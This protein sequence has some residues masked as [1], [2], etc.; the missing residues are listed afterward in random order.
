M[1]KKRLQYV[2]GKDGLKARETIMHSLPPPRKPTMSAPSGIPPLRRGTEEKNDDNDDDEEHQGTNAL[3]ALGL[4]PAH[5]AFQSCTWKELMHIRDAVPPLVNWDSSCFLHVQTSRCRQT[6][7]ILNVLE[8]QSI[9]AQHHLSKELLASMR[10]K[11]MIEKNDVLKRNP[12]TVESVRATL[13]SYDA[14]VKTLVALNAAFE[15]FVQT[16][17]T[18]MNKEIEEEKNQHLLKNAQKEKRKGLRRIPKR[19]ELYIDAET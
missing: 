9:L 2:E 16:F 3:H 7:T 18:E 17:D 6:K 14:S 5:L 12:S 10:Y 1:Q 11:K 13:R 4:G 15:A 19:R 8:E